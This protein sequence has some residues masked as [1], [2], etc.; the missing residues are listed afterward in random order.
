MQQ[1]AEHLVDDRL[2]PAVGEVAAVR[3]VRRVGVFGVDPVEE[4]PERVVTDDEV[5]ALLDR[6]VDVRGVAHAAVDVV[7]AVDARGLVEDRQRARGL[8]RLRDRELAVLVGP[9]DHAL[10]GVEIA[11]GHVEALA[12]LARERS[13]IVGNLDALEAAA[14]PPLEAPVVEEAARDVVGD[15]GQFALGRDVLDDPHREH[16][17]ARV[18][19]PAHELAQRTRDR[20]R[21]A[22]HAAR[23]VDRDA[24]QVGREVVGEARGARH[25][26]AQVRVVEIERP[27]LIEPRAGAVE[28]PDHLVR[29]DPRGQRRAEDRAGREADV[30]I[31]VGD[32]AIDQEVVECLEPA[33]LEGAA[34]NCPAREHESHSRI[35]HGA[36]SVAL[37]DQ[38]QTHRASLLAL[39][40]TSRL[41]RSHRPNPPGTVATVLVHCFGG[42]VPA[43]LR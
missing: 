32:L 24:R 14:Q 16:L 42:T 21:K 20:G 11:R 9:E 8:H 22:R 43:A 35:R 6:D 5:G 34:R 36:L 19:G 4:W 26:L 17:E 38:S 33:H 12:G 37:A 30:E 31:E 41:R 28:H 39:L 29:A 40:T 2:E 13:E 25:E 10:G 18:V 23:E 15:R 3:E 27:Q 1:G 7:D